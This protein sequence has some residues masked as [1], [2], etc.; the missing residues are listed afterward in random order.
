LL[1]VLRGDLIG[2][3]AERDWNHVAEHAGLVA[4]RELESMSRRAR[5]EDFIKLRALAI[6]LLGNDTPLN[7]FSL[8]QFRDAAAPTEACYQA[9]VRS[10]TVIERIWDLRE[11]EGRMHVAIHRYPTQPIVDMLGLVVKSRHTT[12][13]GVVDCLQPSRPFYL[14]VDLRTE[15]GENLCWRAGTTRWQCPSLDAGAGDPAPYF[16]TPGRKAVGQSLVDRVDR[17]PQRIRN[18]LQIWQEQVG[19]D[20]CLDCDEAA[21]VVESEQLEP[22]MVVHTMLS[23]EWEHWGNPRCFQGRAQLPDFVLRRDSV[24]TAANELFPEQV[25]TDKDYWTP[26]L[27]DGEA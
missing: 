14:K 25:P 18:T 26:Q 4:K 3:R 17:R 8:K 7:Q 15:A 1:E 2:W 5:S 6:E 11:I 9:L 16:L 19:V 21:R 23:R 24:G 20:A 22:Q 10:G 13:D 27:E 12:E